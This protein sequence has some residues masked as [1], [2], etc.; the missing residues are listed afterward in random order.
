MTGKRD[1]YDTVVVDGE[2]VLTA[3]DGT[4]FAVRID[5]SGNPTTVKLG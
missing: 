1:A 3:G 2:L 5:A 4:L